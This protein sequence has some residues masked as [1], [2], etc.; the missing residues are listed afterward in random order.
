MYF[1]SQCDSPLSSYIRFVQFSK[2]S[3]VMLSRMGVKG[4]FI[5]SPDHK[6]SYD[7][8]SPGQCPSP[9]PI[10]TNQCWSKF[11]NLK[12]LSIL[13]SHYSIQLIGIDLYWLPFG[14]IIQLIGI[15]WHWALIEGV[16]YN[17][18]VQGHI[19][20]HEK[21]SDRLTLLHV[22]YYVVV[23]NSSARTLLGKLVKMLR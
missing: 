2:V 8:D 12:Y 1:H 10:K 9:M 15:D 16:P 11:W 19:S 22:L 14:S 20:A 4:V 23:L 17:V 13:N 6:R 18:K 5:C 21:V 7:Q 3:F